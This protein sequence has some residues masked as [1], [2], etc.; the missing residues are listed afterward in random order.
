MSPKVAVRYLALSA[1]A[2]ARDWSISALFALS[3]SLCAMNSSSMR[4]ER[5]PLTH[6]LICASV[7]P[8]NASRGPSGLPPGS[9]LATARGMSAEERPWHLR[10]TSHSA[11]KRSRKSA[12]VRPPRPS[13][14]WAG[15]PNS[16]SST[17]SVCRA[18]PLSPSSSTPFLSLSIS[19]NVCWSRASTSG[20]RTHLLG[21]LSS[22]S[23][24]PTNASNSAR[25][26]RPSPFVSIALKASATSPSLMSLPLPLSACLSSS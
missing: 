9:D 10:V 3:F 11:M 5:S 4:E 26:T 24:V 21:P 17:V 22:L 16:M 15:M 18:T 13:K 19:S 2:V 12:K 7:I 1:L 20:V 8:S 23:L 6:S 25:S 14:T